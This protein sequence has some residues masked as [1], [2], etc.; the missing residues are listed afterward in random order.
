MVLN[1]FLSFTDPF[2]LVP[3]RFCDIS[4]D[5]SMILKPEFS[6]LK[7]ELTFVYGVRTKDF[8]QAYDGL[9]LRSEKCAWILWVLTWPEIMEFSASPFLPNH[10]LIYSNYENS[11][12]L[13]RF[14]LFSN[15]TTSRELATIFC[16]WKIPDSL[17]CLNNYSPA[18][19]WYCLGG[20]GT[21]KRWDT[22]GTV[23]H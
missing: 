8:K 9:N 20:L 11:F 14:I 6:D 3:W 10:Q 1:W 15:S 18:S 17:M 12:L 7:E 22:A 4:K 2:V 19:L 13:Y 5:F 21:F 16:I 23:G